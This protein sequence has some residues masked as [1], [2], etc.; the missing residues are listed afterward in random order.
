M[1]ALRLEGIDRLELVEVDCPTISA[2]QVLVRTGAATICTS[3][4]QDI[5]GNPFA[6]DLPVIL[7]HEGAGTIVETG[8]AVTGLRVGDRIAAH[9]VHPCRRCSTCRSGMEH[10]CDDM[11]HFGLNMQGTFAEYFVVRSDRARV[12]P[13][14]LDVSVAALMEPVC[15]S[16]EA[17]SQARLS[18]G[19]SLLILGDGPF[20][21]LMARLA[22]ELNLAN[23]VVA[24]HHDDRLAFAPNARVVNTRPRA[25]PVPEL[26][27]AN[28]GAG[29]DAVILA[30]SAEQA[31]DV[32]LDVLRPKG[33]L[34]VFAPMP[35]KTPVDL[36]RVLLKELEIVGSVND[37]GLL[38]ES[39]AAL[40][41]PQL[42]L[43][44][45]VT[46]RFPLAAY[47]EAFAL[48]RGGRGGAM[49]IAIVFDDATGSEAG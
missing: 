20:G 27:R 36:F 34:V 17:L 1:R 2:D 26:L 6:I 48:A 32:G 49:K 18:P 8:A 16:L 29:Y 4:L 7:G 43:S 46:H 41:S 5:H 44:D 45:L 33:R 47:E 14:E 21:I 22:G 28:E 39:L 3:D 38:R 30:V 40:T 13:S 35:G 23:V 24:G 10:L 15:V 12:I 42:R 37:P 31:L 25:E 9:P 11:G 19:D